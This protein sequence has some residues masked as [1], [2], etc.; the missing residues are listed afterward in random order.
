MKNK[1]V[2]LDRD[3]TLLIPK[4]DNFIYRVGDFNI[5]PT[6]LES[7]LI[8]N[9]S[10]YL[11]F[12]VTNQGRVAKGYLSEDDV[13]SV[14]EHIDRT[15]LEYGIRFSEYAYCPHNPVGDIE[16]YN[17]VCTCRKPKPGL[18]RKIID[19]YDVD[20]SRSWMI[21]DTERDMKAGKSCGLRTILVRTGD[22]HYA[23]NADFVENDL[24]Y[25]VK[26]IIGG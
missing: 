24:S 19:S 13:R 25:A 17:V 10:E 12:M 6:F 8:L 11:L 18:F 26:R 22:Y 7:L 9:K 16:P 5:P 3:K 14:H 21:G 4:D 2:F 1:A 20:V 15:F 23:E